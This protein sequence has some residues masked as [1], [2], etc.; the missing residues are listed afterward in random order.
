MQGVLCGQSGGSQVKKLLLATVLILACI[1]PVAAGTGGAGGARVKLTVYQKLVIGQELLWATMPQLDRP[2]FL[3]AIIQSKNG[4]YFKGHFRAGSQ[5]ISVE[6]DSKDLYECVP[7]KILAGT[8]IVLISDVNLD[9]PVG[10]SGWVQ[11]APGR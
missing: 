6:G 11:V 8:E 5:N 1:T 7:S 10:V 3:C 2:A 9:G 4:G